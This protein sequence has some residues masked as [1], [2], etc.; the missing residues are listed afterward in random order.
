MNQFPLS[1]SPHGHEV[2]ERLRRLFV[3]R[4]ERHICAAME[5]PSSTLSE[6]HRTHQE[7]YCDFPNLDDRV[8]FWN[9]WMSER[10]VLRDDS[11]PSAYLSEMDQG[12]YGGMMGGDVRFLCDPVS[13]WISSMV[14]PILAGWDDLNNLAVD[15]NHPWFQRYLRYLDCFQKAACGRFGLSHFILI[16]GLNFVFELVGATETYFAMSDRPET[17]RRAIQLGFDVNV[18]VQE[19]FFET[20]PL[21]CGGTCSNMV[22]WIPGRI[23]SESVDPF[24]M[25]SPR[26]FE[27]WGR[28]N[29]ERMFAQFD[30][31][32]LHLHANGRHL[33]ESVA[34]VRGLQAVCL[35]DDRGFMSS[36]EFLP[37]ARKR[38]GD[39][40]LI[41]WVEHEDF[42]QAM[43]SRTL[44]NGVLYRVR[45]VPDM[46]TA[47][48]SMDRVRAW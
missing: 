47:N 12:L 9:N 3:D 37:E 32:V 31:G 42:C 26:Y 34:T 46:D 7:G 4:A 20:V 5:V 39:M 40:P 41:V 44:T 2:I 10:V 38:I 25:T 18:K 6:F 1:Y 19:A 8:R 48:R 27:E 33:I 30:G 35:S 11:I 29:L 36:F 14:P 13:G 24:H 22:Q 45:N 15:T 43:A 28:E 21:V 17:V 23:V 16:S